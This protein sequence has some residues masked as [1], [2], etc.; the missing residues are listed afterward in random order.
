MN[1]NNE[2]METSMTESPSIKPEKR[3]P[4]RSKKE[5]KVAPL[6]I[7]LPKKSAKKTKA[8][9]TD[10]DDD[11]DDD[12]TFEEHPTPEPVVKSKR[13]SA[14]ANKGNREEDEDFETAPSF[15]KV[16]LGFILLISL[17]CFVCV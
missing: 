8:A 4:G 17:L 5:K 7:K 11:F 1:P 6:R 10:D 15:D 13:V 16:R 3:K 9:S 12:D 2:T 14:R